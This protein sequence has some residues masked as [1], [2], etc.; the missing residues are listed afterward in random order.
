[1]M[2]RILRWLFLVVAVLLVGAAG[3]VGYVYVASARLLARTYTPDTLPRVSVRSDPASLARGKYLAEHVAMCVECHDEDLGGKILSDSFALGR[4]A[5]TNLTRGRGGIGATYS[6]QDFVRAILHGVRRDGR[7]VTFMPSAD[8]QF[9]EEDFGALVGYVRSMPPVD[10]V[11]P[12]MSPGPMARALGLFT[13]F[14]LAPAA[15]IDHANVR[16][17]TPPN[18]ADPTAT[19]AYLVSTAGCRGCHG[20]DFQGGGGPP[21][22]GSNLTPVG[23]GDWNEQ[24]FVAAIREHKRPNGSTIDEAMPRLYGQ[25]SDGDLRAILAFLRTVPPTGEKSPNQKHGG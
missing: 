19:G 23:I 12:S 10:R 17:V 1:M 15:R 13:D 7:T 9:T 16:F 2:K 4:L 3:F 8:Y 24:Q 22:G 6:D 11:M 25:M 21:P 20:H 14:P 18:A 5:S